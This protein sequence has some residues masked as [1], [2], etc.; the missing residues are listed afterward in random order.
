MD[1]PSKETQTSGSAGLV[2]AKGP[3]GG[4]RILDVATFI[5]GPFCATLLAEFGADVI[6]VEMPGKATPCVKWASSLR[7]WA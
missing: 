4:I 2:E 6:K 5:A 3:L 1:S 7:A